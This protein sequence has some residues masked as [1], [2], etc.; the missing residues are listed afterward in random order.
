[1]RKIPMA[2]PSIT[3][4][5]IEYVND[6]VTN[7]WGEKCYDYIHKFSGLVKT[8][9]NIRHVWPTSSCHGALHMVLMA[10]GVGPGDEVIVPDT[11]WVGSVFPINWLGATPV[12]VDVLQRTW[13]IDPE[14]IKDKITKKTKAIIVVHLYGNLCE[15][16]EIITIG[17]QYGLAVIEDAAEALGSE[18]KGRKAGTIADFGVFS[19]H[20]TK[21]ITTGEGGAVI[22]NRDDMVEKLNMIDGQGRRP[23]AKF[24]W[25]DEIGLKYKMSNLQAAIGL[26]QFERADALV[27]VKQKIFNWYRENLKGLEDINMNAKQAY[28][29]NSYWM[30]TI[31][32]GDSWCMDQEQRNRLVDSMNSLGISLRPFFYPVS[33]FPMYEDVTTNK[34]S[35]GLSRS[36]INLPSYF[37]MTNDDIRYVVTKL[38]QLINYART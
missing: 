16:D 35:Y 24:F 25:V 9:F 4:L 7:G 3:Q 18:Y 14:K 12:F 19:F 34:I 37:D 22:T 5:E 11:T 30:P 13:C 29:K 28:S 2:K 26:A 33:S 6:A 38:I 10:L 21:T 32:F 20:G 8:Y 1:M 15:M 23:G 31:V 17:K 36:G 27:D